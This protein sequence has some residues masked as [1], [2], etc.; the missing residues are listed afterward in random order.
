MTNHIPNPFAAQS[1]IGSAIAGLGNAIFGGRLSPAEL[2]KQRLEQEL[3][4]ARTGN[5]NSARDEQAR[6][7]ALQ[8]Q[9]QNLA[10][11]APGD[12]RFVGLAPSMDPLVRESPRVGIQRGVAQD[13]AQQRLNDLPGSLAAK[14]IGISGATPDAIRA[15]LFNLQGV[16]DEAR[17]NSFVG[18]G[19]TFSPGT[20]L[21]VEQQT[22]L[23]DAQ[24]QIAT[25]KATVLNRNQQAAAG[26][27][28]G[29]T[30]DAA[31]L[32]N[33]NKITAAE[34]L[35][36]NKTAAAD[37]TAGA[38]LDAASLATKNAVAAAEV[39]A[40]VNRGIASTRA[41]VNTETAGNLLAGQKELQ[42][43]LGDLRAD[44]AGL[45]AERAAEAAELARTAQANA[46]AIE[47]DAKVS[48]QQTAAEIARTA[49]TT[50]FSR[51]IAT[52]GIKADAKVK[53]ASELSAAQLARDAAN[54]GRAEDAA[55]LLAGAKVDAALNKRLTRSEQ[56]AITLATLTFE[57]QQKRLT[58]TAETQFEKVIATDGT[59]RL[60]SRA[61][62]ASL[63]KAELQTAIDAG[64]LAGPDAQS[65]SDLEGSTKASL[66][67]AIIS[68]GNYNIVMDT[69]EDA[70]KNDPSI[71]GLVGNVKRLIQN[72]T[73]QANALVAAFG[74]DSFDQISSELATA[75]VAP[76]FFDA[77]LA[78]IPK[79]AT[80]AA[81]QA[82]AALAAQ[83]GRAL[84]DKDFNFFRQ[85]IGDPTA[86]LSTQPA[87][88][89]GMKRLRHVANR[90]LQN[91]I[92]VLQRGITSLSTDTDLSGVSDEDL[93]RAF[94]EA[95]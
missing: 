65:F 4:A 83:E 42:V 34:Q 66:E 35:N 47:A 57:E 1:P 81:Y 11:A 17:A 43:G 26:L 54:D 41:D 62:L 74:G 32:A 27:T 25:D 88:L 21:G 84:S 61:D 39:L 76:E 50:K 53:A 20:S 8:R 36:L 93:R 12:R 45:A 60:I 49:A 14:Q 92:T 28:A 22:A 23:R 82:A 7:V 77:D 48:S 13:Q 29:A 10:E 86:W 85:I 9:Q 19:G 18:A 71:F 5:L 55:A 94:Q 30:V 73:G 59:A 78:D 63:N 6:V 89:S 58:P 75:G 64:P 31:A 15:L 56:E 44:A 2:R 87:F 91:R 68:M 33:T 46:A 16:S 90:M 95:Q 80:L 37:L 70:A 69:I 79:L 72:V 3:L 51:G 24:A 67:K 40:D 38:T 52:E